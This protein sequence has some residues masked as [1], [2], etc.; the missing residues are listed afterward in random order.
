MCQSRIRL[1]WL[2]KIDRVPDN[3]KDRVRQVQS[4]L[5]M[6]HCIL[7]GFDSDCLGVTK[8]FDCADYDQINITSLAITAMMELQ[9]LTT[10]ET[11]CKASGEM[12]CYKFEYAQILQLATD[13]KKHV[14]A[15][16]NQFNAERMAILG[17]SSISEV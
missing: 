11:F 14:E 10:D 6:E 16:I 7:A 8:H 2:R 9:G 4:E 3:L 17:L 15:Q 13:M 1:R 12:E 5:D